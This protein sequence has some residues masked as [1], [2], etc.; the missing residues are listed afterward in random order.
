M[1]AKP[2]P[3]FSDIIMENCFGLL[4]TF[5][6]VFVVG[7]QTFVTLAEINADTKHKKELSEHHCS[8]CLLKL[9]PKSKTKPQ[10]EIKITPP[11]G[12][13]IIIK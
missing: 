11:K 3:S 12:P 13:K 7:A 5:L 1:T 6:I 2:K 4:V 8:E 9:F 10:V